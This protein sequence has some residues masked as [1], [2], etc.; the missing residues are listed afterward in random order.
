[1][2]HKTL[3]GWIVDGTLFAQVK[4]ANELWYNTT[5]VEGEKIVHLFRI[6]WASQKEHEPH[7][8]YTLIFLWVSIQV[9]W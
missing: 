1:M 8:L 3:G 7:K 4:V 6:G 9:G 2:A 5:A